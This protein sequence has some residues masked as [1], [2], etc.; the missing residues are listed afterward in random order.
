MSVGRFQ[1]NDLPR[2]VGTMDGVIRSGQFSFRSGVTAKD[3]LGCRNPGAFRFPSWDDDV[4]TTYGHRDPEVPCTFQ[5]YPNAGLSSLFHEDGPPDL[6]LFKAYLDNLTIP[7]NLHNAGLSELHDGL[8]DIATDLLELPETIKWSYSLLRRILN[9]FLAFRRNELKIR[10]G[11]GSNLVEAS[12][13]LSA[14][15]MEFRYAITPVVKSLEDI[16]RYRLTA[17]RAYVTVRKRSDLPVAVKA[18]NYTFEA[19]VER[20][21][22]AKGRFDVKSSYAGLGLNPLKALY[23]VTPWTFMV[24]WVFPFGELLGTM[25]PPT[26]AT[27]RVLTHSWTVRDVSVTHSQH[28]K[29]ET[30]MS[31]YRTAVRSPTTKWGISPDVNIN[32]KRKLDALA[33]GWLMSTTALEIK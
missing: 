26:N 3:V 28:G 2:V 7:A 22:F 6:A 8:Y 16:V 25:A 20:R 32:W 18:G 23:E 17:P 12:K 14:A 27:Q 30:S 10:K 21:V 33:L 19:N 24:S 31:Y 11:L 4:V 5:F 1:V 9:A 15:W 29:L 13:E